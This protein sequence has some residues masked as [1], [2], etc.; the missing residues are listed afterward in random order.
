MHMCK[1]FQGCPK[2]GARKLEQFTVECRRHVIE[3]FR[4]SP[5]SG[6]GRL[7]GGKS[8]AADAAPGPLPQIIA[9]R[10]GPQETCVISEVLAA[11]AGAATVL[12]TIPGAA[13]GAC[14]RLISRRRS[15]AR[16]STSETWHSLR[17]VDGYI[18]S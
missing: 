8:A 13:R 2:S 11:P 7:A 4:H 15:A 16:N 5:R 12:R 9:P 3:D 1:K 10:Q 17:F 14:P 6:D 18:R